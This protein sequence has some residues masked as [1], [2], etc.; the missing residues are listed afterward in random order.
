[1]FTALRRAEQRIWAEQYVGA[2]LAAPGR[3]TLRNVA[4][5][6]DGGASRQSVHHFISASPWEWLPIRQ[7]LAGYTRRTLNP[8]AWV[9]RPT[10]IPKVGPHSIGVDQRYVPHLGQ[11]V[12]AQQALGSWMVSATAAVPVDWHLLLPPRWADASLRRRAN[13]PDEMVPQTLDDG[14]YEAALSASGL[15]A[16]LTGPVVVD[17][18]G[19]DAVTLARRLAAAGLTFLVRVD[20]QAQLRVDRALLPRYSAAAH[21]AAQLVH[22]S[23]RLRRQVTSPEGTPTALVTIPVLASPE[24][25]GARGRRLLLLGEWPAGGQGECEMWLTNASAEAWRP[26]LRLVRLPRTVQEF[27]GVAERVGVRDFAGRS[28]L[29]WHHHITLASVAHLVAVVQ[30]SGIELPWLSRKL[31]TGV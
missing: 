20:A 7:A 4:T 13:V 28:F 24:G 15:T 27:T 2:L 19:V 31:A 1:M 9:I 5:Q 10:T 16:E 6:I 18:A 14:V 30:E 29:G 17:V 12:N 21:T 3:K 26:L 23:S 8:Q 25:A 22:S 11:V